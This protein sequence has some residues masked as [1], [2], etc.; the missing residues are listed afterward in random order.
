MTAAAPALARG[1]LLHLGTGHGWSAW[2]GD[3]LLVVPAFLLLFLY[4]RGL[5]RWTDRSRPHTAAHTASFVT[6]VA[7]IL[8]ALLSPLDAWSEH[9]FAFHMIQ[10]EL[11]M[12]VAAPLLLLGA[13]TTPLL[14]GLPRG[15]RRAVLEPAFNAGPVRRAFSVL[16]HPVTAALVYIVILWSWHF[17]P[18]WYAAALHH[19]PL[20]DAQHLSF[21]AAALLVWWNVIDPWPLHA[22][23]NYPQRMLFL[24]GISTPKAFMGAFIAFADTLLYQDAYGTATRI[25]ALSAADDQLIGGIIMW[26]PSQMMY[27]LTMAAVFFVWMQK[28]EEE[29]RALEDATGSAARPAA[30]RP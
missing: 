9:H 30:G 12:M 6:G 23:L 7:V 13:P 18:G 11:L 27:L 16:T 24:F 20:H 4:L 2:T 3:L 8:G 14:R 17:I 15:L 28:S 21:L 25:F 1:Q 10:H 19:R 26:V 29:Q 5:D 22:R